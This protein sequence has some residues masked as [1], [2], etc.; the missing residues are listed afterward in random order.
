MKKINPLPQPCNICKNRKPFTPIKIRDDKGT[1]FKCSF[2]A[3][4]PYCGRFLA[5]DFN[6]ID[7]VE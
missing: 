7:D 4:C 2:I 3:H 5:E 6:I 1:L